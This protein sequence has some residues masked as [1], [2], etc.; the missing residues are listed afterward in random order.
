VSDQ[1]KPFGNFVKNHWGTSK[2]VDTA[3]K[4]GAG[5]DAG[6]RLGLQ[7]LLGGACRLRWVRFPHSPAKNLAYKDMIEPIQYFP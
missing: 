7:N 5:C 1:G 3:T 4:Y 2:K 6:A